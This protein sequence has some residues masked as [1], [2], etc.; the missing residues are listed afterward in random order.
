MIN[1]VQFKIDELQKKIENN[2]SK[3]NEDC[4]KFLKTHCSVAV[5]NLELYEEFLADLQEHIVDVVE[6]V[7]NFQYAWDKLKEL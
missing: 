4:I 3:L 1:H 7:D 6:K 2:K 5:E